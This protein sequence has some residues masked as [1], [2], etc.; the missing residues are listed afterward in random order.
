MRRILSWL[1][2]LG[3]SGP[4][5][6]RWCVS[7]GVLQK[8]LALYPPF[9]FDY[10]LSKPAEWFGC[11][12]EAFYESSIEAAESQKTLE[13]LTFVGG[14]HSYIAFVLIGSVLIPSSLMMNPRYSTSFLW[15]SHLE[16]L[17]FIP[18]LPMSARMFAKSFQCC[19]KVSEYMRTS[20]KYSIQQ[21]SIYLLTVLLIYR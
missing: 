9:P 11:S 21:I 7:V 1:G 19:S 6:V 10:F 14:V 4:G 18:D 15:N 3:R 8:L 13:S 12:T 16:G 2:F 17:T 5:P 20:S